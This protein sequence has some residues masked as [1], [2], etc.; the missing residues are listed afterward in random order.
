MLG[1]RRPRRAPRT[2]YAPPPV[3]RSAAHAVISLAFACASCTEFPPPEQPLAAVPAVQKLHVDIAPVKIASADRDCKQEILSPLLT[4]ELRHALQSAGYQIVESGSSDLTLTLTLEAADCAAIDAAVQNPAT[5]AI[6]AKGHGTQLFQATEQ[7]FLT[8]NATVQAITYSDWAPRLVNDL[9]RSPAVAAYALAATNPPV[10]PSA[11]LSATIT[12]VP[13][14]TPIASTPPPS[15]EAA[16]LVGKPHTEAHALIVGISGYKS[17]PAAP[18]ARVDAERFAELAKTTMGLDA[19]HIHVLTDSAATQDGVDR[20][21][22]AIA[23][24]VAAGDR[25]YVFFAGDGSADRAGARLE[26]YDGEGA[27]HGRSSLALAAIVERLRPTKAASVVVF[28]DAGFS[29]SG[30]RA[31]PNEQQAAG[32]TFLEKLPP[33]WVIV[34]GAK[35]SQTTGSAKGK[36]GGLFTSTLLSAIG[37]GAADIDGDQ[38]VSLAELTTWVGPR[39]SRE[40]KEAGRDQAIIVVSGSAIGDPAA[41]VFATGLPNH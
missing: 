29:G 11:A 41:L 7:Y 25:V 26:L 33:S 37:R 32:E 14:A 13:S 28:L 21:L 20:A 4:S 19:S 18:G 22:A 36:D 35:R 38:T 2:E 24:D 40:A 12:P 31:A 39:V 3:K 5:V 1:S 10:A 16:F 27:A 9:S 17:L 30:E 23:K 8:R 6:E 15:S 34:S